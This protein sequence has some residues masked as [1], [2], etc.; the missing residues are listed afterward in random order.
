MEEQK[1]TCW[2]ETF[3]ALGTVLVILVAFAYVWWVFM[4]GN[5][6]FNSSFMVLDLKGSSMAMDKLTHDANFINVSNGTVWLIHKND[7][8][9]E[10]TPWT[11]TF[12]YGDENNTAKQIMIYVWQNGKIS[13]INI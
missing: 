11:Y 1:M 9:C 4:G 3:I 13:E 8:C 10:S 5:E 7:P 2:P 12:G 6:A